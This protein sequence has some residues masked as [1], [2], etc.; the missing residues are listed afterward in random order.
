MTLHKHIDHPIKILVDDKDFDLACWIVRDDAIDLDDAPAWYGLIYFDDN[1][2]AHMSEVFGSEPYFEGLELQPA[3]RCNWQL[4]E[5]GCKIA[6]GPED[7]DGVQMY[8][9]DG[10]FPSWVWSL[11]F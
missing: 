7:V 8:Y 4:S 6:E 1:Q 10:L 9:S 5:G 2:L 3:G 11:V